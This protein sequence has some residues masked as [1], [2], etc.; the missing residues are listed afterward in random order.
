MQSIVKSFLFMAVF[1]LVAVPAFGQKERADDV[2]RLR[3]ATEVFQEIMRTPDKGIPDD[4][5][6]KSTCVSIVPGLKKGGL[7][8]G[9]RYGK[10]IVMCRKG[11]RQWSAPAWSRWGRSVWESS[12]A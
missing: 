12:S 1:A 6:D 8:V 3:R 4:L 11:N 10:G 2:Q 5:L 9:G 7:G